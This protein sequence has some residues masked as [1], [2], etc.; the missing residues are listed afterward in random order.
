MKNLVMAAATG[1]GVYEIEP[2]VNSFKKNCPSADL[3]LF[4]DNI[5]DFTLNYLKDTRG[6]FTLNKSPMI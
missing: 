6:G 2:F 3:V 1:Y 5:S 4:T